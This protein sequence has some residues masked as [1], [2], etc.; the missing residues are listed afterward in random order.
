MRILSLFDGIGGIWEAC[1]LIGITSEL[2]ISSEIDKNAIKVVQKRHDYVENLGDIKN[3]DGRKL[4]RFDLIVGGFPCV[5]LSIANPVPEKRGLKGTRSGLFFDMIRI[6]NENRPKYFLIENVVANN[7]RYEMQ[8]TNILKVP[9]VL[10]NSALFTAQTRRRLYWCNFDVSLRIKNKLIEFQD[11]L[12][13]GYT[14]K[15]KS[16]TLI[17]GM[18][19]VDVRHY[20]YY[21]VPAKWRLPIQYYETKKYRH[22]IINDEYLKLPKAFERYAIEDCK[23]FDKYIQSL[24]VVECERLQSYEDGYVNNIDISKTAKYKL[25]GNSF[26]VEVIAHILNSLVN[27]AAQ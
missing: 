13:S 22:I 4:P 16:K 12:E 20:F 2:A 21:S 3:I 18:A 1:R 23:H 5:G 17:T 7:S 6:I 19:N 25:L 26:T 15:I 10:I 27:G 24:T 11:I 14:E 8:I 9:P